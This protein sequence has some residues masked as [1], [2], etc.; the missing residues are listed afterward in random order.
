[1]GRQQWTRAR[2]HLQKCEAEATGKSGVRWL[3]YAVMLASRRHEELRKKMLEEAARLAKTKPSDPDSAD[4]L[5]LAEY[6]VGQAVQVLQANE[7]LALLDQ[8]KPIYSRQPG[9]RHSM[10]RWTVQR[11]SALQQTGQT[12]ET[13]RV[14]KQLAVEWPRDSGLQQQYAQALA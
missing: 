11:L 7:M 13:L 1:A 5:V 8:L 2:E 3:R 9:H 6:L 4:D 10:K 12:D 14:Q